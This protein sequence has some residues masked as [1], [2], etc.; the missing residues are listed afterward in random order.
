MDMIR[1][2]RSSQFD[3][4]SI[5]INRL[6][7]Y[8]YFLLI[9]VLLVWFIIVANSTDAQ[10]VHK[11]ADLDES[12]YQC[13]CHHGTPSKDLC[14]SSY[15][16]FKT[17]QEK[18]D[19]ERKKANRHEFNENCAS[20]DPGWSKVEDPVSGKFKCDK[21]CCKC[22]NGLQLRGSSCLVDGQEGCEVCNLGYFIVEE[23]D[24][25]VCRKKQCTCTN[26]IATSG[27]FCPV[28]GAEFCET[29][30]SGFELMSSPSNT[31]FL[32]A[33]N[34]FNQN[35]DRDYL[36]TKGYNEYSWEYHLAREIDSDKIID[37]IKITRL[38]VERTNV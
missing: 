5:V 17:F 4:L 10:I 23:T 16:M 9:L 20:C 35:L 6:F 26:G 24:S 1:Y 14:T 21:N 22:S 13:T 11:F 28:N 34:R 36:I 29:C 27:L 3:L 12:T 18:N 8:L 2:L 31:E 25:P 37:M 19:T 38:C 33:A 7:G 15:E 32:K 30:S